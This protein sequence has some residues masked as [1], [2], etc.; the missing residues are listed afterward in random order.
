MNPSG[1]LMEAGIEELDDRRYAAMLGPDLGALD[2]LLADD[3]L[4]ARSNA[5]VDSKTSYLELLRTESWSTT[6]WN[7]SPRR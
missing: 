4:Y 5:S 3:V 7:A 6:S 1:S 2:E